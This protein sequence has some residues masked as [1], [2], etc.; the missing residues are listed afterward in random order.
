MSESTTYAEETS[1]KEAAR[2]RPERP[3]CRVSRF[4]LEFRRL[5]AVLVQLDDPAAIL[6][7]HER[8]AAT[9]SNG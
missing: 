5:L 6:H 1:V 3:E 9:Q 2:K 8:V 4:V 7:G